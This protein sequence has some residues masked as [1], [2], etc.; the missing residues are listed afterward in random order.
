MQAPQFC[1]IPFRS[2]GDVQISVECTFLADHD[3]PHSWQDYADATAPPKQA[4]SSREAMDLA[5]RILDG[6]FDAYIEL[7]LTAGH[8]RKKALRNTPGFPRRGV[9]S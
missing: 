7:L 8:D 9:V 2:L 5:S 4:A 6:D 1:K 3:G